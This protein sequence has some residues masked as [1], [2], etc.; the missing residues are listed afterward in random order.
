MF[1]SLPLSVFLCGFFSLVSYKELMALTDT[2]RE[3]FYTAR[4]KSVE[5][6]RI[7]GRCIVE[8][9]VGA[10]AEA[11][12]LDWVK[13]PHRFFAFRQI[14]AGQV[15][16]GVP[17]VHLK[18]PA[19]VPPLVVD[20]TPN[21]LKVLDLFAG[22]GGL[23][24]GFESAGFDI[25]WAVERDPAACET[26]KR[27]HPTC[28]VYSEDIN[29]VLACIRQ[30]LAGYPSRG[31][32]DVV[33]GGPPCQGFSGLNRHVERRKGEDPMNAMMVT[34]LSIIEELRPSYF[35]MVCQRTLWWS[36]L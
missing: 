10:L 14:D 4:T 30:G 11:E 25:A 18:A 19:A 29:H 8:P 31:Q 6:T 22:A 17:R 1:A 35:C 26:L 32:V 7:V 34:Y 13:V 9:R 21:G 33:V 3:V 5:H 2:E 20:S 27:N 15:S 16:V 12:L 23:S 36:A 28:H 24:S